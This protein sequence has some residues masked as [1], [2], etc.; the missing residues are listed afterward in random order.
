MESFAE[1]KSK[2][3]LNKDFK[4]ILKDIESSQYCMFESDKLN[5][6]GNKKKINK[7]EYEF[8]TG[9]NSVKSKNKEGKAWKKEGIVDRI[10]DFVRFIAPLVKTGAKVVMVAILSLLSIDKIQQ[11]ITPETLDKLMTIFNIAMAV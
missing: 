4:R 7:K 2:K 10:V 3:D 6:K 8:Y 11:V 1:T 9:M 5:K